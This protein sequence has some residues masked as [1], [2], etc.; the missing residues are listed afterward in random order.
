MIIKDVDFQTT[1]WSDVSSETHPGKVGTATWRV[2]QVGD[3][4]IR[5]VNYSPGYI[6]DHWCAKGHIVLCLQGEL[7]T[8]LRDG[9]SFVLKSGM[10][11]Q[12]RDGQEHTS[13]APEGARLFI[14][15]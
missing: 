8:R 10:S 2:R 13:C 4:R 11:Y 9:R 7:E 12:V 1:D 15:D 3:I 6:A 14:V 5:L